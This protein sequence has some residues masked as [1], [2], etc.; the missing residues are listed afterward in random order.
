M[1]KIMRSLLLFSIFVFSLSSQAQYAWYVPGQA[2]QSAE[3]PRLAFSA[4]LNRLPEP[5]LSMGQI[6]AHYVRGPLTLNRSGNDFVGRW[7]VAAIQC[8]VEI[9]FKAFEAVFEKIYRAVGEVER[10]QCDPTST[11]STVLSGDGMAMGKFFGSHADPQIE[12]V[13]LMFDYK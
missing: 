9:R 12:D 11:S 10:M 4:N 1:K 8:N 13:F 3:D 6:D 2:D 7:Y 5:A